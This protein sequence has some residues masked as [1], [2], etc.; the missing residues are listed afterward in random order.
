MGY[1]CPVC[2][3]PQSDAIHLANHLA[4]TALV[5]G[6]D[7]EDWLDDHVPEWESMN[8][9]TLGD[10]LT[11][12]ADEAD[13]PQ[14][15]EDTT[16]QGHG[17]ADHDH[18][19]GHDSGHATQDISDAMLANAEQQLADEDLDNPEDVMAEAREL[20]RKRRERDEESDS[21]SE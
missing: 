21:E 9:E 5:R 11:D 19:D 2:G 20:T 18:V 14:V 17:H 15:F 3:D 16:D 7:H 1:A 8:E 4:F 13:Y 10:R 6:G 12:E